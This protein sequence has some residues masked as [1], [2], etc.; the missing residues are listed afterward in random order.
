MA[1]NSDT[2][3]QNVMDAI[4]A[5]NDLDTLESVRVAALG[6]KGAVSALLKS[7]G[8]MTHEER[9]EKGPLYNGLKDN[10]TAALAARK[11]DLEAQA[12]ESALATQALDVS[13]PA[14]ASAPLLGRVHPVSQVLDEL[15]A[16]FADMDFDI[17][18]GPEIETDY[19]NFTALNI[20]EAH[21]ARQMHDT[22]Y[23]KKARKSVLRTH[24]SP[25]QIRTMEAGDPPFRF[26]AP[27]R[28]YRCDSDQ[29][30]TPMFHQIEGLVVDE[31]THLGHL[32][33]V[34]ETFLA[35]FFEVD[36]V[37][38]RFRPSYFPFTEPSMEVDVPYHK[39]DGR[40]VVGSGDEWL[41]LGGCGMVHPVVLAGAGVDAGRY[42]GFA[43]GMGIDRL[44]MLKYGM[45]DLRAFFDG[46]MRWLKHYGFLPFDVP[47]LAAGLS[48]GIVGR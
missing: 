20:P 6:K 32:K 43:F 42:Q 29:T 4:T 36:E 33:W 45:P 14:P 1:N 8:A 15:I 44:A 39:E 34:L 12:L 17:A 11:S 46:D 9:Q 27:G 2:L 41:E 16:I 13:L 19:Y 3:K 37:A 24:T 5:A 48:S 28:V 18:Q 26:I 38:L 7:L 22:F 21:P 31:T 10:I 25:V 35:R 40:I 47:S 23:M 30:H